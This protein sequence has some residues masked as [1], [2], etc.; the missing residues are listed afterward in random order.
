MRRLFLISFFALFLLA[1]GGSPG[2][3]AYVS[4]SEIPEMR[5]QSSD[6]TP[7]K[8]EFQNRKLIRDGEVSFKTTNV[9]K[10][11]A[12]LHQAIR[13]V[14]GYV[15]RESSNEYSG[16]IEYYFT[17]R[18]PSEN[19]DTLIALISK[20]VDKFDFKNVS[21]TDVSE[22]YIDVESRIKTKKDLMARYR[23]LLQRATKVDEILNIEK[24]IGNL[25]TEIESAE[26]RMRYLNDRIS[27]S[28]LNVTF[29]KEKSTAFG[30]SE[31]FI[32]ALSNGW[33][34]FLAFVIGVVNLWVFVLVAIL[35][36]LFVKRLRRKKRHEKTAKPGARNPKES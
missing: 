34:A 10:T 30:F 26:G 8:I 4:D 14:K 28:T 25:Q 27:M 33:N 17:I 21:V 15:A 24:E 36:L 13:Q 5:Q 16:R 1:C 2:D 35:V 23:E 3:S 20:D 9:E 29:Y 7:D 11:T 6:G 19:F 18:L 31:R 12:H 32:N 22:E